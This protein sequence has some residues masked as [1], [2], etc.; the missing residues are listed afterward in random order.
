MLEMIGMRS[1][2]DNEMITVQINESVVEKKT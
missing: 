1:L 2:V